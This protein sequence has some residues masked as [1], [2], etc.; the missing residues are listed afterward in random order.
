MKDKNLRNKEN[1][2]QKIKIVNKEN[3]T[4]GRKYMGKN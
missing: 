2:N 1:Q 3:G 4:M